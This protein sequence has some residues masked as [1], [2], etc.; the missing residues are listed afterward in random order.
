MVALTIGCVLGG[1]VVMAG[2]LYLVQQLFPHHRRENHNDVAGFVY[3][4]VG[5]LFT[6]ILA[7]VVVNEWESLDSARTNTFTEANELG[8]LY[9]NSRAMPA[10]VGGG[11][12]RTT[13]DYASTVIDQEW[14]LMGNDQSSTTAT[15]LV[16]Q[17]RDEINAL[18]VTTPREQILFE[19][20]LEDVNALEA[21]RRVRLDDS[22]ETVS[23]LLWAVLI[24]GAVLTVGFALL[25]GVRSFW[26]HVVIAAP[27]AVLTAMVLA[28]IVELSHPFSGAAAIGPDAFEIF[29]NKLPPLR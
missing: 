17:M 27:L 26:S 15:D 12:E 14:P 9:W 18:P 28:T 10:A 22:S 24:V 20:S 25:F 13:R 5:V 8:A 3:A 16:Y 23:P 1:T 6:V 19:Q 7:F 4:I 2:L 21:A 11:L 29:L